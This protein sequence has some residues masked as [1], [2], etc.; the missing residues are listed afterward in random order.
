MLYLGV[1]D[2]CHNRLNIFYAL[3]GLKAGRPDTPQ[4]QCFFMKFIPLGGKHGVGRF[5]IVDDEDFEL[6]SKYSWYCIEKENNFYAK[7]TFVIKLNG[8]KRYKYVYMHRYI[9]G[10]SE[11]EIFIDHWDHNG[12]NNQ[13]Y[14]L[15]K[16]SRSNNGC[17]RIKSKIAAS[18][19][20]GVVK[21]GKKWQ[22]AC[23]KDK[24]KFHLGS[25]SN[26]IDAAKAYNEMALKLHGEFAKLNII[27]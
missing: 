6:V 22:A 11:S 20:K 17:N 2:C 1:N 14:N 23:S 12:L 4:G 25:F 18:K 9:L 26:E 15:R 10:I 8:I 21:H 13:R 7:R 3:A 16:A 19:H 24:K 5:A 27:E